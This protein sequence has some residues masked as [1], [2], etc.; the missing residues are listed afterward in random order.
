M[1]DVFL[2]TLSSVGM[3]LIYIGLGYFLRRHHDL[4]K[5]SGKVLSLLCILVFSPAYSIHNLSRTFTRDVVWEKLTLLGYGAI[6]CVVAFL[7]AIVLAKV[8]T[9]EKK[10]RNALIYAFFIPNSGYFGYPVIQMVF[11]MEVLS[12][13]MVFLLPLNLATNTI[14][15]LLFMEDQKVPWS[16]VF[17]SPLTIAQLIGIA[18]GLS[19]WVM[20]DLLRNTLNGLGGCMSP[21]S[22]LLAG[23]MMGKIP[24]KQLLTGGRAYGISL[25]RLLG[26]PVIFGG[27]L[28][29]CGMKAEFLMMPLLVAGMPLG[30]NLVVFPES[31]GNEKM[32][33]E[34][35]KSCFVSYLLAAICLPI[36][37]AAINY[38]LH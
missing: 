8:F 16:K 25:V 33:S 35:A 15:R 22:M 38:L 6:F 12:D 36:T 17:L 7:V 10:E 30:L 37:F 27:I 32:A 26:I 11:G 5:E 28:L 13:V 18:I 1:Q 9:K 34:N 4:P 14:G 23:F 24:M 21:A 20:P 19:G 2:L 29:L 31:L 3:I